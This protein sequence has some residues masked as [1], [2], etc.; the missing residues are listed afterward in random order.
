MNDVLFSGDEVISENDLKDNFYTEYGCKSTFLYSKIWNGIVLNLYL[1]GLTESAVDESIIQRIIQDNLTLADRKHG[2]PVL[3]V[4]LYFGKDRW[5]YPKV[6]Y[7]Y[8]SAPETIKK[9]FTGFRDNI[10]DLSEWVS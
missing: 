6:R 8:L 2:S 3:S 9:Y 10:F 4:V 1:A 7:S 5:K